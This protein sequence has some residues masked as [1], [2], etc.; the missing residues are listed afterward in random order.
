V[1]SPPRLD[2]TRT[3]SAEHRRHCEERSDEAI[4]RAERA[5]LDCFAIA[6]NDDITR[7]C[8]VAPDDAAPPL[9]FTYQAATLKKS[10]T[11]LNLVSLDRDLSGKSCLR[12]IAGATP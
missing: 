7:A 5:A 9:V 8:I 1:A 10:T 6:R 12:R 4:Q 3:R 2:L 11:D